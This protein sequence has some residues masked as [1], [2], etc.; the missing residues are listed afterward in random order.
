M[1]KRMLSLILI[2]AIMLSCVPPVSVY[3]A[4]PGLT[5]E[6]AKNVGFDE[7]TIYGYVNTNGG[8]YFK[9][10]GFYYGKTQSCTTKKVVGTKGSKDTSIGNRSRYSYTLTDLDLGTTYYYKMYVTTTDNQTYTGGV[11]SFTTK[12]DKQSPIIEK[13]DSSAGKTISYGTKTTFSTEVSDNFKLK[14]IQLLIDGVAKK[15][16]NTSDTS[17]SISYTTSNLAVGKHTITVKAWDHQDWDNETSI[18]VTVNAKCSHTYWEE[19]I[20][21][22]E[23]KQISGNYTKHNYWYEYDLVCEDCGETVKSGQ[24]KT[25]AQDH[26]FNTSNK[27]KLCGYQLS[28]VTFSANVSS[29]ITLGESITWSG[30]VNSDKANLKD[31]SVCIYKKIGDKHD[32]IYYRKTSV[33]AKS[34]DLTKIQSGS[35]ITGRT[36]PAGWQLSGDKYVAR[37]N[38]A[39]MEAGTYYVRIAAYTEDGVLGEKEFA[40]AVTKPEDPEVISITPSSSSVQTLEDVQFTVKTNTEAKYGVEIWAGKA[41][42]S[43]GI[44]LAKVTSKSTGSGYLSYTYKHKFTSVNSKT[45]YAYPIDSSGNIDTSAW[46]SCVVKVTADSGVIN[47]P[48]ITT[49]NGTEVAL[50]SSQKITWSKP[51]NVSGTVYYNIWLM[52]SGIDE[53]HHVLNTSMQTAT[54]YTIPASELSEA[55][56]YVVEVYALA[57]GYSQNKS[58]INIVVGNEN[59]GS[60]EVESVTASSSSPKTLQSVTFTVK[61]NEEAKYGVEIWVGK[62][63]SSS[64][65]KLAKVTSK[66]TGSGYLSYTYTHKFTDAGSKTIYAYP[67]DSSGNIDASAWNFCTVNV[68]ADSGVINPP[69][70]TTTN[71]IKVVL[72]SS[73]K[74]TW[75]KPT[76]VS[77]TVYY[78]IWLMKSGI[79]ESHHVLNTSMQ[80]ATSYTIPAS[81]LSEAGTYVVEVYALAQ[82]YS[83]NKSAINIVV[84]AEQSPTCTVSSGES[85]YAGEEYTIKATMNCV[86][87]RAYLL[88]ANADG[89]WLQKAN[90]DNDFF[91]IDVSDYSMSGG[92]YVFNKSIVINSAGKASSNYRRNYKVIYYVNGD[93]ETDHESGIGYAVVRPQTQQLDTPTLKMS[94]GQTFEYG[95][96]IVVKWTHPANATP[97]K[98]VLKVWSYETGSYL[99][100]YNA[101]ISGSLTSK[102][103]PAIN[104]PGRYAVQLYARK[105]RYNESAPAGCNFVVKAKHVEITPTISVS[106][107]SANAGDTFTFTARVPSKLSKAY[108]QLNGVVNAD[109]DPFRINVGDYYVDEDGAYVYE[110]SFRVNDVGSRTAKLVYYPADMGSRTETAV[111]RFSVTKNSTVSASIPEIETVGTTFVDVSSCVTGDIRRGSF[112]LYQIINGKTVSA[113]IG[114]VG[115]I[116]DGIMTARLSGLKANTEYYVQAVVEDKQGSEISSP[117]TKPVTTNDYG[118][119]IVTMGTIPDDAINGTQVALT[120]KIVDDGGGKIKSY[121]FEVYHSDGTP[122]D[123]VEATSY[124][125]KTG[126]FSLDLFYVRAADGKTMGPLTADTIYYV[127]PY[128]ENKENGRSQSDITRYFQTGKAGI[129]FVAPD[130]TKTFKRGTEITFKTEIQGSGY[131]ALEYLFYLKGTSQSVIDKSNRIS[132]SLANQSYTLD[133][134]NLASGTYIFEAR[135][136]M[137]DGTTSIG[138]RE[139]KVVNPVTGVDPALSGKKFYMHVGQS[140]TFTDEYLRPKDADSKRFKLALGAGDTKKNVSIS[141]HTITALA[142]G[143]QYVNYVP[144][145]DGSW[146]N[147]RYIEIIVEETP[148]PLPSFASLGQLNVTPKLCEAEIKDGKNGDMLELNLPIVSLGLLEAGVGMFYNEDINSMVIGY[149]ASN[150]PDF[151]A[152]S[153]FGDKADEDLALVD[154]VIAAMRNPNG[155]RTKNVLEELNLTTKHDKLSFANEGVSITTTIAGTIIYPVKEEQPKYEFYVQI[156]ASAPKLEFVQTFVVPVVSI[157]AYFSA[158]LEASFGGK[159]KVTITPMGEQYL[160]KLTLSVLGE[161]GITATLGAGLKDITSLSGSIKGTVSPS[162]DFVMNNYSDKVV[163]SG[164]ISAKLEAWFSAQFLVFRSDTPKFEIAGKIWPMQQSSSMNSIDLELDDPSTFSPASLDYLNYQTSYNLNAGAAASGGML[165]EDGATDVRMGVVQNVYSQPSPATILLDDGRYL[166]VWMA[167]PEASVIT[168]ENQTVLYY[169]LFDGETWTVPA[170]VD[171]DD[172]TGDFSPVLATDGTNTWLAWQ[173]VHQYL[174]EGTM[175]NEAVQNTSIS[176]MRFDGTGFKDRVNF[177]VQDGIMDF[178]PQIAVSGSNVSVVWKTNQSNDYTALCDHNDLKHAMLSGGKWTEYVAVKDTSMIFGFDVA[179]VKGVPT[180]VYAS[181]AD[182]IYNTEADRQLYAVEGIGATPKKLIGSVAG[183]ENCNP[184]FGGTGTTPKLYWYCNGQI[185]YASY[186]SVPSDSDAV[187]GV[188]NKLFYVDEYETAIYW[189]EGG[190]SSGTKIV[191]AVYTGTGWSDKTTLIGEDGD[192]NSV[193]ILETGYDIVATYAVTYPVEGNNPDRTDIVFMIE[194]GDAAIEIN[195]VRCTSNTLT[196][197]GSATIQITATNTGTASASALK[198]ILTDTVTKKTTTRN[199]D[200][201]APGQTKTWTVTYLVPRDIKTRTLSVEI[202]GYDKQMIVVGESKVRLDDAEVQYVNGRRALAVTVFNEG[203]EAITDL[204]VL[205]SNQNTEEKLV[206]YAVDLAAKETYTTT[207]FLD[208]LNLNYNDSENILLQVELQPEDANNSYRNVD[209][210]FWSNPA[211]TDPIYLHDVT[212]ENAVVSVIATSNHTADVEGSLRFTFWNNDEVTGE[213]SVPLSLTAQSSQTYLADTKLRVMSADHVEIQVFDQN[214]K[215]ISA[216]LTAEVDVNNQQNSSDGS[217]Y[218]VSGTITSYGS[219]SD[220]VTVRLL[221]GTGKEVATTTTTNGKY[222]ISAPEG[223]Y[224]LEVSKLNHVTRVYEVAVDGDQTMQGVKICLRGDVSGDG[225]I[226]ARDKKMIFNHIEGTGLL[227]GY[228]F[229]VGDISGDGRITARDKKSIYNH[230]SGIT[231]LW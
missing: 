152:G 185:V 189:K 170:R 68:T 109:M 28:K 58:A 39:I 177:G 3:A 176:V 135:L 215:A 188:G 166:M 138:R 64:G 102:T 55:G 193:S 213:I 8:N 69:S 154:N 111:S 106:P 140:I 104:T 32:G 197:G 168:A 19:D 132:I 226:T 35:M 178:P 208:E 117:E 115:T 33:G 201:L 126:E 179:Y 206:E 205:I 165:S 23:Y 128:A 54:S 216:V 13:I 130:W 76:N 1:K 96:S 158:E 224:T 52:K 43:S 218:T 146:K 167:A 24:T 75:S 108:V 162:L 89:E 82:G 155:D 11:G 7:A 181:D 38:F 116:A 37:D 103:L 53:S 210:V 118:P 211:Y 145:I 61:T 18:T 29:S 151:E 73:Q 203:Q 136:L 207:V 65:I 190:Q 94:Y 160:K 192:I 97:D 195:D 222:T 31:V 87:D 223:T 164:T 66:S 183:K 46:K 50:G 30:T 202:V 40:V 60:P 147:E 137:N 119:P 27:C 59:S 214:G 17:E 220:P 180:I 63:T 230:I 143:S 67:I 42:S 175:L 26:S 134:T 15:T 85:G 157:P 9:E 45:I 62:A 93:T 47:A 98:Y 196:P 163:P 78:N 90:C 182:N 198:T 129:Q 173:D 200:T 101:D 49:K 10:H 51:T 124:D 83:Q 141:G 125:K 105:S 6:A 12:S 148:V 20:T 113:K 99:E 84:A 172:I 217:S 70:I 191:G 219:A 22:E 114:A 107:L 71:G 225:S 142:P 186:G 2:V 5:T 221:D 133:T 57:Q 16:V 88:F 139:F 92:K 36:A 123:T 80:T 231:P 121:G 44:K 127:K 144:Y 14:K 149:I 194:A 25:V 21:D 227:S 150:D 187:P 34:L 153:L 91:K 86:P 199:G 112:H 81:E 228:A 4:E 184:V 131:R 212:M 204:P 156:V 122:I 48:S 161:L 41:T 169:S 110:V 171:P 120:A 74:I 56:T 79:D 100:S 174:K 209:T 77:G 72:G 95:E 229:D 159:A